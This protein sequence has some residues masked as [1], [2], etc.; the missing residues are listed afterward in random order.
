MFFFLLFFFFF[1]NSKYKKNFSLVL[2][3]CVSLVA[4][5]IK[6]WKSTY[7][8]LGVVPGTDIYVDLSTHKKA[9]ELSRIRIFQYTGAINFAFCASFKRALYKV[10]GINYKTIRS[11]SLLSGDES[12]KLLSTATLIIDLSCVTHMDVAAFKTCRDIQKEM[13]IFNTDLILTGPNDRVYDAL[14]HA[15]MLGVGSFLVMPSIHDAVVYAKSKTN[16]DTV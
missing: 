1:T 4:L 7:S 10:I 5:Y 14:K 3:I 15:E 2:G 6:G 13:E 8:S 16:V 9:K 12:Q 11:A